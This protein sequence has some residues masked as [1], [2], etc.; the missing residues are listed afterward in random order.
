MSMTTYDGPLD[1]PLDCPLGC[2]LGRPAA[3]PVLAPLLSAALSRG[4][5]LSARYRQWRDVRAL[6]AM[7]ADL[8]K[9][10]GWPSV[11]RLP[12]R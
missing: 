8:C 3:T 1:G 12:P 5:R 7:P 11:D 10:L 4:G 9:D 6:E 2:P